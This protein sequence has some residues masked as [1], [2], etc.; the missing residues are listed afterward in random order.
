MSR[1]DDYQPKGNDNTVLLLLICAGLAII[2]GHGWINA[3]TQL[4]SLQDEFAGFRDGVIY[5]G[6]GR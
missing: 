5:G 3:S 1:N 6:Q 4:D 2:C